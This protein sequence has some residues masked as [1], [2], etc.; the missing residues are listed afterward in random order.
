MGDVP[1]F[2]F[3]EKFD[4][5]GVRCCCIWV[6]TL[7]RSRISSIISFVFSVCTCCTSAT[8]GVTSGKLD[9]ADEFSAGWRFSRKQTARCVRWYLSR[10]A[11]ERWCRPLQL[12]Q[13]SRW[14]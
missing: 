1:H 14:P 10:A 9:Q 12:L 11:V 13:S 3:P 8:D 2:A 6:E 5:N 4:E 7:G